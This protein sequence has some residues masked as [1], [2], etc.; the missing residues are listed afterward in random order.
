MLRHRGRR[1]QRLD[2]ASV[3]R[4]SPARGPCDPLCRVSGSALPRHRRRRIHYKRTGRWKHATA[5]TRRSR[6]VAACRKTHSVPQV[7][8]TSGRERGRDWGRAAPTFRKKA[9]RSPHCG[10]GGTRRRA[11][12]RRRRRAK[13]RTP[14]GLAG[15]S[16]FRVAVNPSR[17]SA[18]YPAE[19]RL[20]HLPGRNI[21]PLD[22]L[23]PMLVWNGLVLAR[24]CEAHSFKGGITIS[25]SRRKIEFIG[26][27]RS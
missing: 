21:D 13:R 20:T 16:R 25:H 7:A 15:R 3:R 5:A 1:Q 27:R 19:V 18:P 26:F 22:R 23:V 14:S 9:A 6:S 2:Q 8:P 12:G 10:A 24:F 11:S 17:P 4:K